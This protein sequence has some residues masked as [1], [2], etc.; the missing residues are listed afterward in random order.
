MGVLSRL[1]TLLKAK[2][3]Q[4]LSAS[5]DP[6]AMLDYS[7]DKQRELLQD[8][9]RGIVEVVTSRRRLELQ[10]EKLRGNIARLEKQSRDALAAGREDLARLAIQ[11]KQAA[12]R[13]IEGLQNQI[14]DLEQE[15]Q[16]LEAAESKL[17]A[18]VEGFRS[19]KEVT[20]ARYSAAEAQ[21]RIGEAATGLSEEMASVGLAIERAENKTEDM[22][23]RASAIDELVA[24]GTLDELGSPAADRLDRELARMTAAQS[25]EAELAALK[26]Q[27]GSQE[28]RPS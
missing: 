8:V 4:M 7:Y 24:A 2:M 20:K 12:S 18:K 19:R 23:A 1:A 9:K 13:Q 22:R 17:A 21:V 5:E 6:A 28:A 26:Q 27:V 10:A 15:Q 25:V 14:A 3:N 11:R 16:N